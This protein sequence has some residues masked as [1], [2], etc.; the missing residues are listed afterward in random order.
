M[1]I[2]T[3]CVGR[4]IKCVSHTS[5]GKQLERLNKAEEGRIVWVEGLFTCSNKKF[6][7]VAEMEWVCAS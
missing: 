6:S 4:E 3:N 1:F 7:T 2:G 5:C